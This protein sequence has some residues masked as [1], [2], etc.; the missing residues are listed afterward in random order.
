MRCTLFEL[1]KSAPSN[2]PLTSL[3]PALTSSKLV[4]PLVDKLV[5]SSNNPFYML[6]KLGIVNMPLNNSSALLPASDAQPAIS[7]T[8]A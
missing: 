8:D 1:W 2:R 7:I 4:I 6:G 3:E 5:A